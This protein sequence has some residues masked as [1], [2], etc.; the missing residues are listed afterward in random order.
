MLGVLLV[1]LG[2]PRSATSR[3]VR[4]YLQRFL[5]DP[6]VV[7]LPRVLWWPLLYGVIAPLRAPRSAARYRAI[8]LPDGSAHAV[9]TAQV[10]GGP[11]ARCGGRRSPRCSCFE[12]RGGRLTARCRG[13]RAHASSSCC[14]LSRRSAA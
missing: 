7:E 4:H 10:R 5:G 2:T 3:D 1:N 11:P 13:R 6:R 12:S 9:Y 8:W 14:R